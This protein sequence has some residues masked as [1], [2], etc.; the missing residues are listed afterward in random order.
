VIDRWTEI[1]KTQREE[2]RTK[3]DDN[4]HNVV[5]EPGEVLI[6]RVRI[7]TEEEG[8]EERFNKGNRAT[9]AYS[10]YCVFGS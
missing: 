5:F 3:M 7:K 2:A 4:K 6:K 8:K 10:S 1:N 9:F